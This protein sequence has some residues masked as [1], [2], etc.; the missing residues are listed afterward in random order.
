[1]EEAEAEGEAQPHLPTT[2]ATSTAGAMDGAN[3]SPKTA[4]AEASRATSE[5]QLL[6][7][8]GRK[9]TVSGKCF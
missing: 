8:Y 3:T 9:M 1:M 5:R 6:Q 7:H 4:I 2:P